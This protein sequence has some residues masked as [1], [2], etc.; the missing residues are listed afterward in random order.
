M[1]CKK[2][3]QLVESYL[4]GDLGTLTRE[5]VEDHLKNCPECRKV[6]S[7]EETFLS[8]LKKSLNANQQANWP[9]PINWGLVFSSKE[10]KRYM[11]LVPSFALI[12]ILLVGI[13]LLLSPISAGLINKINSPTE[14]GSAVTIVSR[15]A[16]YPHNP[17][18]EEGLNYRIGFY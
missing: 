12:L 7:Q 1:N 17:P 15:D 13:F 4:L 8:L 11:R 9:L 10:S 5:K 18:S 3:R 6:Y 14:E 2:V 16:G